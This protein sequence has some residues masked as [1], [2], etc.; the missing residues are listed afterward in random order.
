MIPVTASTGSGDGS[1]IDGAFLQYGA[2]GLLALL[3]VIAVRILYKRLESA[4][5]RE[6]ERADRLEE[7]LQKLN[8]MIQTQTMKSLE[9]A[10]HAV[11]EAIGRL[12]RDDGD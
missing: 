6:R 12:K 9:D 10:T 8:F 7:E 3:A 2:I 4:Y 1:S 5:D 11:A